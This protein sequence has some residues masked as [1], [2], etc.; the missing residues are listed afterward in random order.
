MVDWIFSS[1]YN[2]INEKYNKIK[3]KSC[4]NNKKWIVAK[5]SL[6]NW[7]TEL[8]IFISQYVFINI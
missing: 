5:Q 3:N 4:K 8:Y 6:S 7:N 2:I 1:T